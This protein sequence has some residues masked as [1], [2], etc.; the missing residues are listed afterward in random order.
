M[1][2]KIT[3]IRRNLTPPLIVL[4]G[5][6]ILVIFTASRKKPVKI[7]H[8]SEGALVQ[9]VE[10]RLSDK[11]VI[12]YGSGTVEPRDEITLLPQVSGKVI[13]V[14][15]KL[16]AGGAF[17]QGEIIVKI[18]STDYEFAVQQAKASLAQAEYL[19]TLAK[20]NADIAREE[21]ELVNSSQA[22]LLNSDTSSITEPDPLVLHEPQLQQAK[23]G[24]GSAKA[25]LSMALLN[26]ERTILTA[27]FNCRVRQHNVAVGQVISPSTPVAVLYGTDLVEIGA[28]IAMDDMPFIEIPGSEVKVI[29]ETDGEKFVWQG[30]VDRSVGIVDEL[31]QL[32]QVVVQVKN[33]FKIETTGSME[34]SIGSFVAVEIIGKKLHNVLE[35]PR[36]SVRQNSTVWLASQDNTL[37]IRPVK[38]KQMLTN[39]ALI[40]EGISEGDRVVISSLTG[41]AEGTKLRT[42]G[43]DSE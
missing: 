13:W 5:I 17:K 7:E 39:F 8:K 21:W 25:T 32:A 35:I 29:L 38:I 34:L 30:I 40:S 33:P 18:E 26:L 9:V 22:N 19:F 23:A 4:S 36:S 14:S 20:A 10:A 12:I 37:E 16:A 15:P 43:E 41:A 28:G 1:K 6:I 27:P 31:G 24:L 11:N 2:A 42:V 3:R